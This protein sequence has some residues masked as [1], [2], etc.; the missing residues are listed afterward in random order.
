MIIPLQHWLGVVSRCS[1][2]FR[3]GD[4]ERRQRIFVDEVR[5][6]R[7]GLCR[8]RAVVWKGKK[9][10]SSQFTSL[11]TPKT[12]VHD[13]TQSFHN[14]MS[15]ENT[16]KLLSPCSVAPVAVSVGKGSSGDVGRVVVGVGARVVEGG[17]E[18]E[19]ERAGVES[20]S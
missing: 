9:T 7:V 15:P 8:R 19:E 2:V 20:V 10:F 14:F 4:L 5:R 1:R 18:E 17:A 6:D 13:S 12:S 11:D 16:E 3:L